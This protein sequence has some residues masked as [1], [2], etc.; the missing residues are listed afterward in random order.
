MSACIAEASDPDASSRARQTSASGQLGDTP[1]R[2]SRTVSMGGAIVMDVDLHLLRW[3]VLEKVAT[4][5]PG[6]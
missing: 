6:G 4:H 3:T 1:L 2:P 5:S